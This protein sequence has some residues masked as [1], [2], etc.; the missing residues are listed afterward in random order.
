MAERV[1]TFAAGPLS[2]N[3]SIIADPGSGEAAVIGP[4]GEVDKIIEILKTHGPSTTIATELR[5]NPFLNS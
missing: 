1:H 5:N 2:C 4:G 3:C